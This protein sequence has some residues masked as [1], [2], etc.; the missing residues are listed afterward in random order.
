MNKY[1][2]TLMT[3]F[4]VNIKIITERNIIVI[5]VKNIVK[6]ILKKCKWKKRE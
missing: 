6:K 2:Q 5:T 1:F 3:L 4:T